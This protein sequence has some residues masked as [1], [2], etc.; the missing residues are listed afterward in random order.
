LIQDRTQG[1]IWFGQRRGTAW[2]VR[3]KK[4]WMKLKKGI[5]EHRR[6]FERDWAKK[7]NW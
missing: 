5:K 3:E 1:E 6:R 2:F 4:G 7:F